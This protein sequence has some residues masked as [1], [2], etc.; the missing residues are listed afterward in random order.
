MSRPTSAFTHDW[1]WQAIDALAGRHG[2]T[3]SALAKLAGLDPTTFNMSKRFSPEGRPR[4]PSTESIAKV[5][6]ATGTPLDEF[7]SLELANSIPAAISAGTELAEVPVIGE[8]RDAAVG[9]LD[10]GKLVHLSAARHARDAASRAAARFAVAIADS[11]LEPAYSQGNTL[12]V[13]IAEAA[14]NGDRVLVQPLL[15]QA[16]PGLLLKNTRTRIELA[17]FRPG[18]NPI[19]LARSEVNWIG[20]IIWARQ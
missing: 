11:S 18:L 10:D 6:E 15:G 14:R 3:P 17:T 2:L 7:A 19:E 4:W 12:I 5:L 13:S 8:V 16:V 20:R 9:G 1:I